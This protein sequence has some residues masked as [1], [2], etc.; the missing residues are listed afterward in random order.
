MNKVRKTVSKKSE[1]LPIVTPPIGGE[2]RNVGESKQQNKTSSAKIYFSQTNI[3]IFKC[4][5]Y[6]SLP[7]VRHCI[8][9]SLAALLQLRGLVHGCVSGG[10]PGQAQEP[11]RGAFLLSHSWTVQSSADILKPI[12]LVG[13]KAPWPGCPSCLPAQYQTAA[14]A[15]QISHA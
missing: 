9:V 10:R 6:D 4:V 7:E 2:N 11:I 3:Q 13:R 12:V 5:S 14:P 15:I 8:R 1:M